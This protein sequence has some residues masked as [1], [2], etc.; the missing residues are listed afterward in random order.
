MNLIT[1]GSKNQIVIPK[2]IRKKIK[3]F[4]PGSKLFITSIADDA[5]TIKHVVKSWTERTSGLMTK[6]WSGI[7]TDLELK[8]LKN[9]WEKKL[10]KLEKSQ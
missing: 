4:L 10:T 7:D 5:I 1:V 2:D 3:G 6:S 9:E 8:K